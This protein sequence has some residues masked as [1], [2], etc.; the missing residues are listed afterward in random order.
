MRLSV[1]REIF[2]DVSTI[3][4]FLIDGHHECLTLGD[5][6][7]DEKIKGKTAIPAGI[8]DVAFARANTF[9]RDMP[10]FRE[11]SRFA[12]HAHPSGQ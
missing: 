12:R 2:T 5:P 10:R 6:V 3:E 1:T 4:E 9:A 11:R 8:Y 7:R